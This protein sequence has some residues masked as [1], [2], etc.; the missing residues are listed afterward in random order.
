MGIFIVAALSA[1]RF[2]HVAPADGAE[3]AG[4][5]ESAPAASGQH[6][7]RVVLDRDGTATMTSAPSGQRPAFLTGK[8]HRDGNSIPIECSGTRVELMVFDYDDSGLIA[9]EW[10]RAVWGSAGPGRLIRAG[11]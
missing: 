11:R 8:W 10:D 7:M 3:I 6:W 1:W 4:A 2:A 5:Y 9:R